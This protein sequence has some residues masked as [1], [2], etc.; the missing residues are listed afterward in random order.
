MKAVGRLLGGLATLCLVLSG[1]VATSPPAGARVVRVSWQLAPGVTFTR[2]YDSSGPYQI[3]VLKVDPK[4]AVMVDMA[5]S[6]KAFGHFA[7]TSTIAKTHGAI[8][9]IN[10]DFALWPGRPQHTFARDGGL[11]GTG[12]PNIAFAVSQD[13]Q[14]AYADRATP[15]ITA[16]VQ[17]TSQTFR[18]ARWNTSTPT[19]NDIDGYTAAGGNVAP[20]PSSGCFARL[21]SSGD[22][23]WAPGQAGV[24]HDYTVDAVACQS[25]AMP[26]DGGIV[27][28]SRRT[29][30]TGATILQGL[31]PGQALSVT[32]SVG[33]PDVASLIGGQP[34]LVAGGKV[35]A[36]QCESYFCGRNPRTGIGMTASGQILLVIVDGRR[37]GWSIGMTL[38]GFARELVS[39]GAVRAMNLDGGGSTT[40]WLKPRGLVNRPS[41]SSGE[42]P[43]C[44]AVLV[45]PNGRD[46]AP[47]PDAT[48]GADAPG[49][50][51]PNQVWNLIAD[52]PGSTGGLLSATAAGALGPGRLTQAER[53]VAAHFDAVNGR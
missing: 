39:L 16:S 42:R 48:P 3:R 20:V 29:D 43:V 45:L 1:M 2:I 21:L 46:S 12:T 37:P 15:T 11:V 36:T 14:H 53:R 7:K 32:W 24:V 13:E 41:D 25:S 44:S 23:H 52:D 6:A 31:Q 27:L 40:M 9:A 10:G 30:S 38:V 50:M 19:G 8:A 34:L 51:T 28:A 47:V 5:L 49:G 33:W 17:E 4:R 26:L 35:V 18:V 22:P